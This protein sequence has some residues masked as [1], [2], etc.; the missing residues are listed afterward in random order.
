MTT[1]TQ[2]IRT[3]PA[4]SPGGSS[5]N[6]FNA[7]I[8]RRQEYLVRK[9]S[10]GHSAALVNARERRVEPTRDGGHTLVAE[11]TESCRWLVVL[12]G[13]MSGIVLVEHRPNGG[14]ERGR[15]SMP[16]RSTVPE[17][18]LRECV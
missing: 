3:H 9:Q 7:L 17:C 10:Q 18:P 2:L 11:L 14:I 15:K 13:P 8:K 6:H 5:A 16:R 1:L 4:L 12:E